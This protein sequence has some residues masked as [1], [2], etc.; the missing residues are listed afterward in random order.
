MHVQRRNPDTR[1][2]DGPRV[3]C[4]SHAD[5]EASCETGMSLPS[6]SAWAASQGGILIWQEPFPPCRA[7][8]RAEARVF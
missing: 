1:G 4:A 5:P 7:W 2:T 8:V 6:A 3:F